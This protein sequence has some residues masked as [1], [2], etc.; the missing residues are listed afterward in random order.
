MLWRRDKGEAKGESQDGGHAETFIR[1]VWIYKRYSSQYCI[2]YEAKQSSKEFHHDQKR[3]RVHR[4]GGYL[5][6]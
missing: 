2:S 1:R 4:L 3:V 5:L 6:E